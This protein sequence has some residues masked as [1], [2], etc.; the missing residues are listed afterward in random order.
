MFPGC[1]SLAGD[2]GSQDWRQARRL[3]RM[4]LSVQPR[5]PLTRGGTGKSGPESASGRRGGRG[6]LVP[7]PSKWLH[8]RGSALELRSE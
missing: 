1:A 7:V 6:P 2:N 8:M 3:P 4:T 5:D